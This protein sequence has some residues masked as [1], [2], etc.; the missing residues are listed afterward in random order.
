MRIEEIRRIAQEVDRRADAKNSARLHA[1][2]RLET[3]AAAESAAALNRMFPHLVRQSPLTIA[4]R[5]VFFVGYVAAAA[6]AV[7]LSALRKA[8]RLASHARDGLRTAWM[9]TAFRDTEK[10]NVR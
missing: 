7:A 1:G 10:P 4:I 2:I 9:R 8:P 3:A 5:V 6:W